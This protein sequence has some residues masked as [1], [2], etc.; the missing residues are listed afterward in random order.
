MTKRIEKRQTEE[1]QQTL[2]RQ[3]KF[4]EHYDSAIARA[5]AIKAEKEA[6]LKMRSTQELQLEME[7]E[8][9]RIEMFQV[10]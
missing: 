5:E 4:T 3:A 8:Q 6:A 9:R 2:S 7:A 10:P 1:T